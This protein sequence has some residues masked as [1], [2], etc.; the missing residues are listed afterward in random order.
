MN[1]LAPIERQAMARSVV[2]ELEKV[3]T[4]TPGIKPVDP[5]TWPVVHHFSQGV[6][7]REL[8]IPKGHYLTGHI[9]KFTHLN[10]LVSGDISVLTE[11]GVKRVR[12][13]FVVVSPAGTKRIAYAHEDTRWLTVHGTHET[14]VKLI[15]EVFIAHTEQEFLDFCEKQRLEVKEQPCLGAQ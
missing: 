9:H 6:Y 5:D 8:F 4:G 1:E 2:F 11:E 12:P 7:G 15:E 14:D 10:V 13:P 3:I